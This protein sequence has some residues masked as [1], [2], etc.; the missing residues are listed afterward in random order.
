MK[1][2][3]IIVGTELLLGQIINT[4]GAF[5]SKELADLGYEVY[6]ETTVGDNQSR[7]TET[8]RLASSRSEL[9]ILCGGLGPTT[10][11]LTKEALS[12]F[13]GESLEY[14]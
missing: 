1:T 12:D 11:D 8:I 14:D 9:V 4:N 6:F 5:L 13:I 7:L 3:L 10:D 2:E